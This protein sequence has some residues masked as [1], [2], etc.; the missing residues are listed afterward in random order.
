MAETSR[1]GTASHYPTRGETS[2]QEFV[3]TEFTPQL[4]RQRA[5]QLLNSEQLL[6][7]VLGLT[8]DDQTKIVEKVDEVGRD[9]SFFSLESF[10]RSLLQRYIRPSTLKT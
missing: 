10:P 8:L 3:N 6:Q 4:L 5:S 2:I 7:N 9:G 1:A